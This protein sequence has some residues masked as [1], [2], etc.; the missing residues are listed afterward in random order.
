MSDR[1]DFRFRLNGVNIPEIRI[2]RA[3]VNGSRT[4]ELEIAVRDETI[5][6]FV[7]DDNSDLSDQDL[8]HFDMRFKNDTAWNQL[9]PQQRRKDFARGWKKATPQE[10][11]QVLAVAGVIKVDR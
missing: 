3:P 2:Q 5:G 9:D 8:S 6:W 7:I 10:V 1:P 4:G 11:I